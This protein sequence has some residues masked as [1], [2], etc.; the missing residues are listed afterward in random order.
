MGSG[1]QNSKTSSRL[2]F[3]S[4]KDLRNRKVRG[5]WGRG[6]R[7][8]GQVRVCASSAGLFK[9]PSI[10]ERV[11]SAISRVCDLAFVISVSKVTPFVK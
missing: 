11:K 3:T 8:Y 2:G 9:K 7:F 10:D 4:A 5:I 6:D 1:V